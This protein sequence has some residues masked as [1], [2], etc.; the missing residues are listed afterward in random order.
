MIDD[1]DIMYDSITP[2][3]SLSGQEIVEAMSSVQV[4]PDSE[5]WNCHFAGRTGKTDCTHRWRTNDR[6]IGQLFNQLLGDFTAVL[7][8]VKLLVNHLDEPRVIFPAK[9][10][11]SGGKP[12]VE[13]RDL[14]KTPTWDALVQVC[15]KPQG[16]NASVTKPDVESFGL[17][18]VQDVSSSKDICKHPSYRHMHGML[19]SP[20]SFRLIE[21]MVPVLS[22]GSLS[23]MGD[24][25]I[26]SPAYI[27]SRFVYENKH[28][29]DW[30][31]KR[32]NLYW[33]G[34]T[35][36][37]VAK[38]SQWR[39]FHRQRFVSLAQS[40]DEKR[41]IYLGD[42]G[43]LVQRVTSSFLNSKLFDVAFTKIFSCMGG[44]CRQQ[45]LFYR[46]KPWADKD[47]A[48]RSRLAFDLDGNGIS[49]RWYK[50]VAS[51][52]APLKQTII[53]E[54]HDDRLLPWV[55]FIPVSPGMEELPELVTYLT[56]SHQGR[57][58][59]RDIADRGRA[60]FSQA[61]RDVDMRVYI[62]R[63]VLELAR[64][65]DPKRLAFSETN[66]TRSSSSHGRPV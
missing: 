12:G 21:G 37:G 29:V 63:L 42:R 36:G 44:T 15:A 22:T 62:Y 18:F 20:T 58:V 56:S 14:S 38:D 32:N 13:H 55:H 57:Q 25:L 1:F 41:H 46:M 24:I 17:P 9:Q 48:L 28:D 10:T 6:H 19:M 51:K 43:G 2:L 61:L 30:S 31:K 3:W 16:E 33:A 45:S 50:L 5:L 49:G 52:S 27:E 23:T 11:P 47:E 4:Y 65:Q 8:D 35:S 59:A 7:P 39:N 40:L 54:W 66:L 53:R 64:L 60:W 34:S 26:P